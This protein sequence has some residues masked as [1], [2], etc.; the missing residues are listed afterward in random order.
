MGS[1]EGGEHVVLREVNLGSDARKAFSKGAIMGY[2]YYCGGIIVYRTY[3]KHYNQCTYQ[4]LLTIFGPI[5][6]GPP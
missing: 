2:D 4:F 3:G 5:Y 6:Y 1:A